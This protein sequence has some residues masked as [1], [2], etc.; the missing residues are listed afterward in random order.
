MKKNSLD[1]I[2]PCYNPLKGWQHIVENSFLKLQQLIPETIINIILIN[3]GSIINLKKEIDYLEKKLPNFKYLNL[4]KNYGKGYAVRKG[5]ELSNANCIVFTDID[6]PYKEK[7]IV[8]MYEKIKNGKDFIIGTRNN[9]YYSKVPFLRKQ[10]SLSFKKALKILFKIPTSD[11]QAGL[12]A[13]SKKTKKIVLKTTVNRYLFDLELIKLAYKNKEINFDYIE[14]NLK[15]NII[16]SQM[17]FS[18]LFKEFKNLIK[19]LFL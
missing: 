14:L 10:L 6:F 3:D 15:D 9:D 16:L 1:I 11:T 17:S 13:F 7:N 18:I 2:L 4:E 5:F 8:E 12:K 19:I